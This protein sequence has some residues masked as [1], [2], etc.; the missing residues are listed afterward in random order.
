MHWNK[1]RYNYH[2]IYHLADFYANAQFDL[3][4]YTYNNQYIDV[5][6][7]LYRELRF[8]CHCYL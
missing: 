8:T 2:Y 6:V 1:N 3:Y 4:Y 5:R 7:R